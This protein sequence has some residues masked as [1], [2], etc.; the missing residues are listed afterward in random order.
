MKDKLKL[1][2]MQ[3]TVR[4]DKQDNLR[5][6]S[7]ALDGV[8]DQRPDLVCLGEMFN[9]PY[10]T[11]MFPVYAEPEALVKK[12][13]CPLAQNLSGQPPRHRRVRAGAGQG[14]ACVQH[15]LRI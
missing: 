8:M 9:C 2:Q 3:L 7:M 13:R 1:A 15:R 12:K 10:D 5:R 11:A 14:R 4:A 6:L